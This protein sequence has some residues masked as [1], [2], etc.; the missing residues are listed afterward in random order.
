MNLGNFGIGACVFG[1]S[2]WLT[3]RL[4]SSSSKVHCLD[5]PNS[6]SLHLTPTPRTGG[7]AIFASF[8]VGISLF[9]PQVALFGWSGD[10]HTIGGILGGLLLL[11]FVSFLD[12]RTGLPLQVR[13][14]THVIISSAVVIIGQLALGVIV[15]P[16]LGSLPLRSMAIP[17]TIFY[18]VWM[19][20]LYNYRKRSHCS[21]GVHLFSSSKHTHIYP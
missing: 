20:N 19:V 13:L 5:H 18:L 12:D 8:A 6:R 1:L 14:A 10:I 17:L 11:A 3:K 4:A 2:W 16:G 9:V 15:V 21:I 7:L